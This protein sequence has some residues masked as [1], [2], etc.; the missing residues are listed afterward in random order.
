MIL[1]LLTAI[2]LGIFTYSVWVWSYFIRKGI[3]GPRGFPGIGMLIQTIDHE[4]P[5]F[6]KYR[7]WT[8]QYGPVWGFTEGPQQT[9]VI[10]EPEMVNE[11]FNKQ[12]DNFYGRKLRPIIGDPEKDKR[13][14]LFAAQGKRWKRLRAMSSPSFSNNSLRK[15]KTT[16][17]EC[18]TEIL[19]NI[20]KKV[21][22]G[23]DIDMLLFY[24]EYTLGVISRI[25]LGQSESK[26]FQNPLL[27]K[28]KAIFNGSFHLFLLTG[29]FPPL[30]ALIRKMSKSLPADFVPAFKIFDLIE[31]AVEA[32]I[33]QREADAKNGIEP[34]EPQDFI[35]L[36]LDAR[37]DVDFFGEKNDDFSKSVAM[38]VNRELTFDEIVGQCFV[39]LAAGFDTTAL[40]LSYATYLLATH[41][42]IQK[43][44]QEEVDR[45]CP[46]PEINFDQLSKLRYMECVM[47]EALRLYPLG[48]TANTRKCM[49]ETTIDGVTFEEGMNIQVDTWTLHHNPRVWGE[50]VE[51]FKPERWENSASE[52]LEHNGSY[53]PFGSGPRQCIGMR[54]AQM[55]QKILLAQ[56]LKEY[57]FRTTKNT[58]IPLKLVG[59]LTLSP[60]SV[61]VKLEPRKDLL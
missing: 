42:E 17:Q 25:A 45:E 29:V 36:F 43:K 13:V 53:I 8:K 50:D 3:K 19:W 35:D 34:G 56:I 26:M 18:G 59:K 21:A 48:V 15:V 31:T 54:L 5:P 58:Q 12:F 27:P 6:L 32:R 10:S 52:H 38:K 51:D 40:S 20:E 61:I 1:V 57:S 9:M 22:S 41:P 16:V 39:F 46:D 24:Q 11:I 44:L 7:E 30:A 49:R 55:E 37:S 4:N 14:N 47:K 60:E 23:E 2:L 33:A 28:V